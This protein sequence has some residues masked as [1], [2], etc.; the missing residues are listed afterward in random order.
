MKIIYNYLFL[1]ILFS[2][3]VGCEN[4]KQSSN[5]EKTDSPKSSVIT[6][7]DVVGFYTGKGLY[8]ASDA[9]LELYN[10]GNFEMDDPMLPDGGPAYGKWIF[11]G[12][13]VDFYMDGQETFSADISKRIL[14]AH[15]VEE[16][17][18]NMKV[19]GLILRGQV[20]KKIR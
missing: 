8:N 1:L 13:S 2:F 10:G 14:T 18:S 19:G 5:T 4:N 9:T 7:S 20:W 15:D 16:G 6:E 3:L 11:R 17:T 12:S